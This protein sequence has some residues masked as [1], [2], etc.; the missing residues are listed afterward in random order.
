MQWL[1]EGWRRLMFFVRRGRFQR[2]LQEEMREHLRMK[3]N[4]LTAAGV[5]PEEAR[6]TARREFGNALL[7]RESSREAWG[8]MWLE[9]LL[10][11]LR[12]G[13]RQIRRN[14]GFTVVA[15][16]TLALGI[17][18]NTAVFTFVNAILLE[19]LPYAN[20]DPLVYIWEIWPHEAPV[21]AV[22][23]PD[24]TN[25]HAHNSVFQGLAAYGGDRSV[26]LTSNGEPEPVEGVNISTDFF[27]VL[28]VRP[29]LGRTFLPQEE[30]PGGN[31]V[32]L[33]GHALWQLRFGSDPTILGRS[34]TLDDQEYTVVGVLP[35]GFRF[36]D[37]RFDPQLFLPNGNA[38]AANW[39]SPQYLALPWG[40]GRLRG[41]GPPA[42]AHAQMVTLVGR[43]A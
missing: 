21:R 29:I 15:V 38:N 34:I 26:N 9:V 32:V 17:G 42:Q 5:P 40:I 11:D 2:D 18:A 25:W 7:L 36:P 24:F 16:L 39:H 43:T 3:A 41:G 35:A 4:D 20:P 28:G 6:N 33:I 1:G 19:P 37:H 14:P 12:Y 10:Q 23:T 30:Q 31:L 8:V 27:S 13:L 22:P